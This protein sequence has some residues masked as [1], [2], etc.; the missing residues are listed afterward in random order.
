MSVLLRSLRPLKYFSMSD[1][2][3]GKAT[4][5]VVID[6]PLGDSQMQSAHTFVL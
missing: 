2:S 1:R 3:L 4:L 5:L 6:I